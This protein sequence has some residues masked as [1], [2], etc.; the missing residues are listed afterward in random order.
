[1]NLGEALRRPRVLTAV[2]M[3]CRGVLIAIAPKLLITGDLIGVEQRTSFDMRRQMQRPEPTLQVGNGS[4]HR[5]EAIRRDIAFGKE[6]VEGLFLRN[7]LA[8]ERLG[9]RA[10]AIEIAC[11]SRRCALVSPSCPA[12]A[13]TCTGP[14]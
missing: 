10:D 3:L 6:L 14:G 5:R 13:S 12:S 1:M 11:T 7:Q 9:G 8:A 4:R 2:V